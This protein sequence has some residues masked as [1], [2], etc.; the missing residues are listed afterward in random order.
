[1]ETET[2]MQVLE[3][4]R[5]EL[6]LAVREHL[7]QR[8]TPIPGWNAPEQ[9]V[10]R[11]RAAIAE[12]LVELEHPDY[13]VPETA[14][15]LT[16][17]MAGLGVLQQVLEEP[18]VEEVMVRKGH[19][20]V[21]KEGRIEAR[22]RAADD[23]YFLSLARRAADMGGRAM[24]GDRPFVLVDLPGGHRFTAMIPPLSLSGTAI[25]IRVHRR[26]A[27]TLGD[28]SGMGAFEGS[29]GARR[30]EED[31]RGA[32]DMVEALRGEGVHPPAPSVVEF[33]ARAVHEGLA[34][35]IVSGEFSSGKTTLLGALLRLVPREH[36]LAVV[37]TFRELKI[38]HPFVARAVVPEILEKSGGLPPMRE[39]VNVLYTRMR[40]DVIVFGEVVGDE[41]VPLLD[42][43]NLGKR[44]LTTIHGDS[45]YGALLRLEMLAMASG[46]PLAAIQ[47]R[48]A[49]GIDLVVHMD[50]KGHHRY[51]AEVALVE[52]YDTS[53]N[54][55]A[56]RSL[57]RDGEGTARQVDHLREL[58][59][60]GR[61]MASPND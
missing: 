7:E 8:G 19:L 17:M 35:I 40:P 4:S 23:E 26:R 18:G 37:E 41:A 20:L 55:Y 13:L 30:D 22:G 50:R 61:R 21:E 25:N 28:L 39:V 5:H 52:G 6:L 36:V 1:M 48:V 29:N 58:W 11:F 49:R 54:R 42:A 43:M 57:Y 56:L 24:W 32:E 34:S 51:V 9:E 3:S 33:L 47:E 38:A 45:A 59:E 53:E 16:G 15:E 2:T 27:F 12:A 44:V 14:E 10:S 60:F 31:A 46:L